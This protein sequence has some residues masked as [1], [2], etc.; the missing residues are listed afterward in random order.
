MIS[1]TPSHQLMYH[2]PKG[3]LKLLGLQEIFPKTT[4]G[5]LF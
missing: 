2:F 3:F 5:N 1:T 4:A